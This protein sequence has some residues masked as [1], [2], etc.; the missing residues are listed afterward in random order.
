MQTETDK[1]ERI[2]AYEQKRQARIDR[3]RGKAA[4][5]RGEA[6]ERQQ[7]AWDAIEGIPPGQPILVGHHSEKHHRRD[8]ARHDT[9][10]RASFA[11]AKKAEELE[12]AANA[13][14]N[15][16]AISSDDP[17][18]LDKLRARLERRM[19]MQE[20]MRKTNAAIRMRDTDAGDEKLRELGFSDGR[21]AQLRRGD[22]LGRVGYPDYELSNNNADIRRIKGRIELLEEAEKRRAAASGSDMPTTEHATSEGQVELVE[23]IAENRLQFRFQGKPSS[24]TRHLL[25]TNGFIWAPSQNSWQRHLNSAAKF[26]AQC[27]L[28][29][30]EQK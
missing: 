23:N 21:I 25:K 28:D 10:M 5:L 20:L 4:A 17:A 6:G 15:N 29:K 27:V 2:E 11:A 16:R 13:A 1:A 24:A 14:E 8:L 7:S 12:A 9:N 26:A 19:A 22:F 3:L 30:I 18:A